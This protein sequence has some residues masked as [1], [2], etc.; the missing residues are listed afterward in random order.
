MTH[1]CISKLTMIGS[2]N[3]LAP[4]RCQGIYLNQCQV[5]VNWTLRNKSQWNFNQIPT[6]SLMKMHLKISSMKWRPFCLGGDELNNWCAESCWGNAKI[7]LRFVLFLYTKM[8]QAVEIFPRGKKGCIYPVFQHHGCW[9]PENTKYQIEVR[10][11]ALTKYCSTPG[12][13]FNSIANALEIL[14]S[15]TILSHQFARWMT[16]FFQ[17]LRRCP[18]KERMINLKNRVEIL[19]KWRK[20]FQRRRR[21]IL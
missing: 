1:I 9:W 16:E 17:L 8:T 10:N 7:Y 11:L 21:S 15:C 2:D 12:F 3:G 18:L 19:H 5:F 6:F 13:K 20:K 14:Q 4:G